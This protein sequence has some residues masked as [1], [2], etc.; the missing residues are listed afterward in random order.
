MTIREKKVQRSFYVQL[1]FVAA[2]VAVS[3]L[4]EH[5]LP[6]GPDIIVTPP[7]AVQ[8]GVATRDMYL[9]GCVAATGGGEFVVTSGDPTGSG[10]G[11]HWKA[12]GDGRV[13]WGDELKFRGHGV[14]TEYE[15]GYVE[16]RVEVPT[17]PPGD[18]VRVRGY[19]RVPGTYAQAVKGSSA[20]AGRFVNQ[21][22]DIRSNDFTMYLCTAE[23]ARSLRRRQEVWGSMTGI[24]ILWLLVAVFCASGGHEGRR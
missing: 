24:S 7:E 4:Q 14:P 2:L 16:C 10:V 21:Q 13:F 23:A 15:K 22:G 17:A 20:V 8:V 6:R 9:G 1:P 12:T 5:W 11:G 19:L 3:L 18:A